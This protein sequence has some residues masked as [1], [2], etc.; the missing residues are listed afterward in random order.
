[1]GRGGG[2]A[3]TAVMVIDT[4]DDP[5]RPPLSVTRAISTWTPARLSTLD[6]RPPLP[7]A[8]PL[9]VHVICD[10]MVPS[11][12]SNAEATSETDVPAWNVAPLAG[13]LMLTVGAVFGEPPG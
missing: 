8:V 7:M 10:V 6:T 3:A 5:C 9:S 1:M 12:A 11:W 2:A 13:L 4:W